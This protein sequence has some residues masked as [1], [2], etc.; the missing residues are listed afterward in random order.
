MIYNEL[1]I[2]HKNYNDEDIARFIAKLPI[3]I[4]FPIA[5][6]AEAT[7]CKVLASPSKIINDMIILRLGN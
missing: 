7:P 6:T 3:I 5:D 1:T 2:P 4:P